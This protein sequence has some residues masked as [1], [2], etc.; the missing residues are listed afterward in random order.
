MVA[1]SVMLTTRRFA[2][3]ESAGSNSNGSVFLFDLHLVQPPAFYPAV[4][5]SARST[6][7]TF[8]MEEVRACVFTVTKFLKSLQPFKYLKKYNLLVTKAVQ[9]RLPGVDGVL[10]EFRC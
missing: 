6:A 8:I 10:E 2:F 7:A 5:C 9:C 3:A 1:V 4:H